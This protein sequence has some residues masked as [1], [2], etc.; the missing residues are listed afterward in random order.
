VKF[1]AVAQVKD[2]TRMIDFVDLPVGRETGGHIGRLVGVLEVPVDERVKHREAQK[3]EAF[4]AVIRDAA[5]GRDVGGG[6][7]NPHHIVR[8]CTA[9]V[10]NA[11]EGGNR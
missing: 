4:A 2:P 5:G 10:H 9:G 8:R 7:A 1:D 6:H 3:S 11:K